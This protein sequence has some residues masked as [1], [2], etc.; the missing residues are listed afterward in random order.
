LAVITGG[1]A[2]ESLVKTE[3]F[4]P[5]EISIA[6]KR[7]IRG[8]KIIFLRNIALFMI[9]NPGILPKFIKKLCKLKQRIGFKQA[10][11]ELASLKNCFKRNFF[12]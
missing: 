12:K 10:V 2:A 4:G 7:F 5:R 1:G 6:M 8:Y 3:D 9:K 11:L